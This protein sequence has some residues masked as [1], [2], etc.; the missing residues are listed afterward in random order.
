MATEVNPHRSLLDQNQ[1]IQRAF[2]ED[3]DRLRVDSEITFIADDVVLKLNAID[4][5]VS[6]GDKTGTN[7]LLINPDGSINVTGSSA[8]NPSVGLNGNLA[9]TS[10]TEAG[11]ID[12]FGNLQGLKI[13]S[14][15]ALLVNTSGSFAVQ[16]VKVIFT[17]TSSIAV[18][19]ETPINTY[20]APVGKISYLL[21]ILD[22]GGNRSKFITYLNGVLFD[23]QYTPVTN[24]TALFD[25]KT[26]SGNI[27][28][29]VIPVGQIVLAT[30]INAGTSSADYNSRF[31]ILEVT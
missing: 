23:A 4:D 17:E 30:V 8:S 10:S 13:D 9:P 16:E 19:V 3:K 6:I 20:T 1:I 25:Y 29:V 15:G 12:P 11:A 26:G 21:S 5:S 22:S 28:G 14:S 2:D 24:L 27:P 31:L 18:G 7:Y